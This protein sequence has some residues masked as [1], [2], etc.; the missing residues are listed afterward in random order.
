MPFEAG[1]FEFSATPGFTRADQEAALKTLNRMVLCTYPLPAP[2][3]GIPGRRVPVPRVR[4]L[5]TKWQGTAAA[6]IKAAYGGDGLPNA[7][8]SDTFV[9]AGWAS[10]NGVVP[11]RG[12]AGMPRLPPRARN[13]VRNRA[14]SSPT[15]IST[16]LQ[17]FRVTP[18]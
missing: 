14:Q 1:T 16:P 6:L 7:V 12:G 15:S 3:D 13:Q 18:F 8:Y 17:S 11:G 2:R 5:Q 9:P 10:A 4:R